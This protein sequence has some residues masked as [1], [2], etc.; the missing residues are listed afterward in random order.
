MRNISLLVARNQ[1]L[2]FCILS[3]LIASW[4]AK[5]VTFKEVGGVVVVEAEHFDS[6]KAATDDDHHYVLAP[7]ELTAD[8]LAAPSGQYLN[9]RGGKYMVVLPDSPGGGQNRNNP[10]LQA[11]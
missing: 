5:A 10:D 3:L 9:A 6:R 8:E 11:A 2:L 1:C 4:S 7:D